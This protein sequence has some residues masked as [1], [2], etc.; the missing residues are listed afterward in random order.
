MPCLLGCNYEGSTKSQKNAASSSGKC[1][2]EA[3]GTGIGQSNPDAMSLEGS[4]KSESANISFHESP[5]GLSKI[6][7][8]FLS[9]S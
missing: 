9:V 2:G 7:W 8:F 1:I 6:F 5:K 4:G 3:E